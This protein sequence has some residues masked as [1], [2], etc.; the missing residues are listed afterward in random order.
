LGADETVPERAGSPIVP[1]VSWPVVVVVLALVVAGAVF[2]GLVQTRAGTFAVAVLIGVLALAVFMPGVCAEGIADQTTG[3]TVTTTSCE[4]IY[5]AS[6]LE[7]GG[8]G[9]DDSGWALGWGAAALALVVAGVTRRLHR[10]ALARAG[11]T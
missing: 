6:L 10:P 9:E 7:V 3:D 11:R 2:A 4:T 1:G 5:G 8:L